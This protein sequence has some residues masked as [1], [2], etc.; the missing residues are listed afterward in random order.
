VYI[1]DEYAEPQVGADALARHWA[2]LGARITQASVRTHL[3]RGDVVDG[4]ARCV[5]LSRWTLWTSGAV[6][7]AAGAS[8]ITWLAVPRDG[9]YRI[10]LHMESE[11]HLAGEP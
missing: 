7:P 3:H 9:R 2:R 4:V 8:W 5:L 10:A 1:G 6:A 11:V